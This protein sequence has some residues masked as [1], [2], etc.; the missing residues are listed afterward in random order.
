MGLAPQGSWFATL[1]IRANGCELP[2]PAS[3][4]LFLGT[5]PAI[6]WSIFLRSNWLQCGGFGGVRVSKFGAD[7]SLTASHGAQG[8]CNSQLLHLNH[9]DGIEARDFHLNLAR[10]G[11][12]V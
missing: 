6:S 5:F 7:P 1:T 11:L 3:R 4:V 10:V 9:L 12:K 2:P 8:C